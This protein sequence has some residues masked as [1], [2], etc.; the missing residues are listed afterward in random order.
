MEIDAEYF[1]EPIQ[2]EKQDE[3]FLKDARIFVNTANRQPDESLYSFRVKFNSANDNS[4][5]T[6]MYANSATNLSGSTNLAGF[7]LNGLSYRPYDP[8]NPTGDIIGHWRR[9]FSSENCIKVQ[10]SLKN[11]TKIKNI[12]FEIPRVTVNTDI[13]TNPPPSS[14]LLKIDE[15]SGSS[16]VSSEENQ[17]ICFILN[18]IDTKA[19]QLVYFSTDE[20]TFDPPK[21]ISNMS[22]SFSTP[23]DDINQL[24]DSRD[25]VNI[26]FSQINQDGF[27]ELKCDDKIPSSFFTGHVLKFEEDSELTVAGSNLITATVI[28]GP[29]GHATI[30][31]RNSWASLRGPPNFII[32]NSCIQKICQC[33]CFTFDAFFPSLV[34]HVV[35]IS[36]FPTLLSFFL[37]SSSQIFA[38]HNPIFTFILLSSLVSFHE[39]A[40]YYVV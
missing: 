2:D 5:V 26:S 14:I 24:D 30:K 10:K 18:L 9:K 19:N 28:D 1:K 3:V 17:D 33:F 13:V 27:L 39:K 31:V 40:Q 23:T 12:R 11:V 36:I 22:L 37:L 25:K 7:T 35:P 38:P 4:E 6:E 29:Y 20:L 16:I 15:F 8:T 21:N 34:A 32:L